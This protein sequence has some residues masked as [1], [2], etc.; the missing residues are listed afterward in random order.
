[1]FD[2]AL[3]RSVL[4]LLANLL[5]PSNPPDRM[6]RDFNEANKTKGRNEFLVLTIY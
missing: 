5:T 6:R 3:P 1:M 4:C 2:P